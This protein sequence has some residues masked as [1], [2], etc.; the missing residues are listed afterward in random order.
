MVFFIDFKVDNGTCIH[1]IFQVVVSHEPGD[2]VP[3]IVLS[4]ADLVWY[5]C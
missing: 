4:Y 2:K 3:E 1:L 5:V